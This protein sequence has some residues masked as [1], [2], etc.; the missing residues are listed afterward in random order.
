MDT[1]TVRRIEG[2][3]GAYDVQ[4]C[5]T[6]DLPVRQSENADSYTLADSGAPQGAQPR[7]INPLA[8]V[9]EFSADAYLSRLEEEMESIDQ[10]ERETSLLQ[11]VQFLGNLPYEKSFERLTN[12]ERLFLDSSD[13]VR[14]SAAS[15]FITFN[16]ETAETLEL[17][18]AQLPELI[19][20]VDD[21]RTAKLLQTLAEKI[22]QCIESQNDEAPGQIAA[23][24]LGRMRQLFAHPD[25]YVRELALQMYL[26]SAQFA[27]PQAG[28]QELRTLRRDYIESTNLEIR[29]AQAH[30]YGD[31]AELLDLRQTSEA[32]EAFSGDEFPI[33]ARLSA[34]TAY[35]RIFSLAGRP[36]VRGEKR[37]LQ[38]TAQ[39]L[40]DPSG[41]AAYVILKRLDLLR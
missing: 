32:E 1:C 20:R 2:S 40:S 41:F 36:A 18:H 14:L 10:E 11:Y 12:V 26:V 5:R 31:G 9:D 23:A 6:D 38:N 37:V 30:A 27:D 39:D 13:Q 15:S 4:I 21:H 22:G 34:A 3:N 28:G 8:P 17:N 16:T 33:A 35:I 24:D 19:K 29:R 7:F 25:H